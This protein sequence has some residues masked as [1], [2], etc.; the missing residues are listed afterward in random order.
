MKKNNILSVAYP[1]IFLA[2]F[3]AVYYFYIAKIREGID[4][5]ITGEYIPMSKSNNHS[6]STVLEDLEQDFDAANTKELPKLS[7][8]IN[9]LDERISALE[10]NQN[11]MSK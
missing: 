1:L 2:V 3:G 5:Q 7:R 4:G 10:R 6:V 9:A 8:R 11:V